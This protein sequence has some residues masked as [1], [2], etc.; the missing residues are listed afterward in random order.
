MEAGPRQG[1]RVGPSWQRDPGTWRHRTPGVGV[2]SQP[3][4]DAG[5]CCT[6]QPSRRAP[7]RWRAPGVGPCPAAHTGTPPSWHWPRAHRDPLPWPA[8]PRGLCPRGGSWVVS[9]TPR[10]F[11]AHRGEPNPTQLALLECPRA[12]RPTLALLPQGPGL[13]RLRGPSPEAAAPPGSASLHGP[14]GPEAVWPVASE[15]LL[16]FLGLQPHGQYQRA[17]GHSLWVQG[18]P[19]APHPVP[20]QGHRSPASVPQRWAHCG[21][22]EVGRGRSVAAVGSDDVGSLLYP[23]QAGKGCRRRTDLQPCLFIHSITRSFIHS[24]RNLD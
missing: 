23:L 4:S 19:E 18:T 14:A 24:F 11:L 13:A 7:G 20:W 12:C 21:R 5:T 8:A 9:V 15:Q 16:A 22:R 2:L 6:A 3:P 17:G 10:P 1:L